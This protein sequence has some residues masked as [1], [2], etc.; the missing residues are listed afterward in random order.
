DSSLAMAYRKL[1]VVLSNPGGAQSRI[2]AAA[3]QA[4]RHR[5]RLTPFERDL[6]E[7]YYYSRV[8]Y[9][10]AKTEAAY[11]AALE[12]QPE[13]GVALNNLSLLF[14][15]RRR[16]ADAESLAV[17]GLAVAPTQWALYTNTAVAQI[18]QAKYA[19]AGRTVG[20]MEQRSPNNPLRPFLRGF[21]ALAQRHYDSAEVAARALAETS[22]DPTWQSSAAGALAAINL[23][24]GKLGASEAQARRAMVFDEQRGVP[25][26]SI[27]DAIGIAVMDVHYRHAPD[28]AQREVEAALRRH[29]LASIPAQD[30][31]YLGLAWLYADAGRP[32]RARQLIA[33][34]ETAVPEGVRRGEPFRHGAAAQIAFAEGRIP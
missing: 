20:L 16:F 3:T 15:S 31:P 32:E 2:A 34:Y 27:N 11:R 29:P 4:F 18:G 8:D 30:R 24:R 10:P 12:Q 5:D 25:G 22:R 33:E 1:A 13:N 9:D 14:N 7:A 21:L 23:V 19:A 26:N 28:A 6:A 17:R